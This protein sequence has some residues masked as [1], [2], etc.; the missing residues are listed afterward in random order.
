MGRRMEAETERILLA[1]YSKY[2]RLAYSYVGNEQDALDVVQESAY[3]A[4]RDCAKVRE[5]GYL[6]TWIYR[7]VTNTAIDVLRGRKWESAGLEGL[8]EVPHEDTYRV[9]GPMELLDSLEEGERT[10]LI[11][12]YFEEMKL[13]EIARTLSMNL[14]TVKARLYRALRKL[15]LEME[16]A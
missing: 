5:P 8:A 9:G 4:I 6:S 12:R 13:E 11:L 7:I 3:K 16:E 14:N 1:D 10:I 15:R 2:Y